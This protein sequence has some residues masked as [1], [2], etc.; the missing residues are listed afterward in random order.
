MPAP[1][2]SQIDSHNLNCFAYLS[3]IALNTPDKIKEI[4]KDQ[5][6]KHFFLNPEP[7]NPTISYANLYTKF[8]TALER[9]IEKNQTAIPAAFSAADPSHGK[10]NYQQWINTI[11]Q[12]RNDILP[13]TY[14]RFRG[15]LATRRLVDSRPEKLVRSAMKSYTTS[16]T[17]HQY[18]PQ[19]EGGL[20][21]RIRTTTSS[22][23]KPML[24]TSIPSTRDYQYTLLLRE[25]D[26]SYPQELRFG[27]Q[28]Q[29]H[30]DKPRVSPLFKEWL[31]QKND[32]KIA[33]VYFNLLGYDRSNYEGSKERELSL[34]LHE[35]ET[36]HPNIVVITLPADQGLM[37][38]H[39]Y[40]HTQNDPEL[41]TETFFAEMMEIANGE[42]RSPIKDFVISLKAKQLLYGEAGEDYNKTKEV[43]VLTRLLGNSFRAMGLE[44]NNQ[45]LLSPAQQQAIWFHFTKY[46]MPQY[47]LTALQPDTWNASCKDAIDRGGVAS[48]YL[49]L[50]RSLRS[51]LPMSRD[52][53]EQALHAAATLVKGRGLNHHYEIIWNALDKYIDANFTTLSSDP[54][55]TWL[56]HWRNDNTPQIIA[57]MPSYFAKVLKQNEALLNQK[58]EELHGLPR[59][60]NRFTVNHIVAIHKAQ[61][62]LAS[63]KE[64]LF[65]ENG[66]PKASSGK[67]LL[68]EIVSHTAQMALSPNSPPAKDLSLVLSELGENPMWGKICGYFK[69][70]VGFIVS[71]TDWGK[72]LMQKGFDSIERYSDINLER[73]I[74][75]ETKFKD[76]KT[77]LQEEQIE[78]QSSE[79]EST[80]TLVIS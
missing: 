43:E 67:R 12:N 73:R 76:M 52:E 62:I 48:A 23:F 74:E 50:M 34:A 1:E 30:Q 37:E 65:D 36:E 70:F 80:L 71:F 60:H 29:R 72:T 17:S 77:K 39:A 33:H 5:T 20:W 2:T 61:Q 79:L 18:T 19:R 32:K 8:L 55:K 25:A 59:P 15:A 26:K 44:I 42:S 57:R 9:Q 6:I 35:L 13:E 54:N 63:V 27:T 66:N 40:E 75:I 78:E 46:E 22:T 49:N 16:E 11:Y 53:F 10:K 69:V 41:T 24:T 7:Y 47:V 3:Q 68:L 56:I 45:T 58:L 51:P 28:G 4:F 38:Q 64:Q 21:R 31:R 14:E